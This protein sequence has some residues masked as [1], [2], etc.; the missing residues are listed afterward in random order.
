MTFS[1][2][3]PPWRASGPSLRQLV[4][5]SSS[6]QAGADGKYRTTDRPKRVFRNPPELRRPND[7]YPT[8]P[9]ATE[10]LLGRERFS[11]PIL[12]PACGDGAIV[13]VLERHGCPVEAADL[14]SGEDFFLRTAGVPNIIT[15]PPCG[16]ALEFV[17]HAK[18][19]ATRKI[20][21]LLPVEFLHGV[22]R[23]ELCRDRTFPVKSVHVFSSRLCFGAD[24]PATVGH[25][26]YVWDRGHRAAP[27][28]AWIP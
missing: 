6:A 9:H 27:T 17:Y 3:T 28:L 4:K 15:N 8:P 14:G 12:A 21:M 22:T 1:D 16:L 2:K 20:A 5:F 26:W 18:E 7:F 19:V 13:R 10:A 24:T 25:A 23:Y 11:G